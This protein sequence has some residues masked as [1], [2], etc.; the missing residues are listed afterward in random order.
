LLKYSLK[1]LIRPLQHG[2]VTFAVVW[3]KECTNT[4]GIGHALV[5]LFTVLK[6]LNWEK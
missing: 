5:S 3:G 6:V 2:F 4:S 1:W